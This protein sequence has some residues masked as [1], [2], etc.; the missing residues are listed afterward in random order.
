MTKN[1]RVD[2]VASSSGQLSAYRYSEPSTIGSLYQGCIIP[3]SSTLSRLV[4]ISPLES[5]Y[6][7]L[8]HFGRR[9]LVL[10]YVR[11]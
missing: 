2:H 11:T 10:R 5:C 7:F 6:M 4:I 3:S 1:N 9:F 8:S